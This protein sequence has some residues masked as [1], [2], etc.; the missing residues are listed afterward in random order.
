MVIEGKVI[1][2]FG[3][4]HPNLKNLFKIKQSTII[5]E[6]SVDNICEVLRKE[7]DK[8]VLNMSSLLSLKKDFAFVI[9]SDISAEFLIRVIKKVDPNIGDIT[10]FDVYSNEDNSKLSLGVE[11][12]IIQKHKVLNAKE[13]NLLMDNIIKT[14]EKKVGAKLRAR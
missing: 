10:V 3:E 1:L 9:N 7:R 14:V 2:S 12:E 6:G 8:K 5:C 11:V 4:L 13:I